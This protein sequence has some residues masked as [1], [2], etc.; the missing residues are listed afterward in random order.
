MGEKYTKRSI[1]A[2]SNTV[3]YI[4]D[5]D[6]DIFF[7]TVGWESRFAEILNHIGESFHSEKNIVLSFEV[8]GENGYNPQERER[9]ID[10]LKEHTA[11]RVQSYE[12]DYS[13]SKLRDF[14]EKINDIIY[15]E[16]RIKQKPLKVGFE[17]SSCPRYH[18]LSTFS[19]C[20][21]KNYVNKLALFY[22]EGEYI[23]HDNDNALD[24][25]FSSSG[26]ETVI[27]PNTGSAKEEEESVFVFSLGFE[28]NFIIDEIIKWEPD[29]VVFLCANPGYTRAYEEKVDAEIVRI[30]KYCELPP[31]RYKII[32]AIAGD[33]IGAWKTLEESDYP[34]KGKMHVVHYVIGTK[35]HCLAMT[36]NAI[37]S[38][39]VIVKYRYAKKYNKRDVKANGH[40]WRYDIVNLRVVG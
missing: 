3:E 10:K 33:A 5:S 35:P 37:V 20:I 28:A 8:N 23:I 30:V 26:E 6:F 1:C 31:S 9:F 13:K 36:L 14:R 29:Y 4:M 25:F 18:F 19:F 34:G 15:E 32:N 24:V 38:N 12:F 21:A 17:F 22:S 27:I 11:G 39:N 40:F 2:V 16:S 7:Y